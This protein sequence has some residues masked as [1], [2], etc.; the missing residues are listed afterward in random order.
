MNLMASIFLGII[1]LSSCTVFKSKENQ[2][3]FDGRYLT[4]TN[5]PEKEINYLSQK[6][7]DT[8][9]DFILIAIHNYDSHVEYIS[10]EK[11]DEIQYLL[12]PFEVF[13][14]DSTLI[15]LSFKII[16]Y[17][18][19]QNPKIICE[20]LSFSRSSDINLKLLKLINNSLEVDENEYGLKN[21]TILLIK[22][23]SFMKY[24]ES[25]DFVTINSKKYLSLLDCI[26]S[27]IFEQELN[28]KFK[29]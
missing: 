23:K 29:E 2:M 25:Q 20:R 24:I 16:R 22:Y 14:K 9:Q 12:L 7:K 28:E 13:N 5:A 8:N 3:F 15:H 26:K 11:N 19:Y 10:P 1:L 6:L 17:T 18:S 4:N 27:A 21:E